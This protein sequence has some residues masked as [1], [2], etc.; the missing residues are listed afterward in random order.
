[1]ISIFKQLE[2]QQN[3][4]KII[5]S[6]IPHDEQSLNREEKPEKKCFLLVNSPR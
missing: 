5:L 3:E 6:S 4:A 2:I 1:M